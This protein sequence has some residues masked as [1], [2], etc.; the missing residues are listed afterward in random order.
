MT[1]TRRGM[2]IGT[3]GLGMAGLAPG[4]AFAAD[5]S[6]WEGLLA[7]AK[8][9]TVYFHAWGGGEQINAYIG[10]AAGEMQKRHGFEVRHVQ[11]TDTANVVQT[12][13]AEKTAGKTSGGSVDLVWINGENFAAMKRE[14]L[15]QARGWAT[16]LPDYAYVDTKGKPT[17][18]VDFTIPTDGLE[19]PWGMAQLVF[20]YDSAMTAQPPKSASAYLEYA[21]VH[22]GRLA[23][24]QP[25]DFMGSTFLKQILIETIADPALL[26][27][28]LQE[29]DFDTA[30]APLFAYLDELTPN[31]WRSGK[32]YPQNVTALMQ[33]LSDDEIDIAFAFNPS[34]AS[35]DVETGA[36]PDTVRGYVFDGGTIG[37]THFVA[38]PFNASAPAGAMVFA[39]FLMSPEAQARK[40]DA[41]VWGDP[42]VLDVANLPPDQK[43]Y[44]ANVTRGVAT[45]SPEELGRVLPEPHPSWMEA[46]ERAWTARYGAT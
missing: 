11:V 17:T 28:P 26:Q 7:E 22:P 21:Q 38:I 40:A 10:W 46:I 41:A 36:L 4:W 5:P 32:A 1:I 14:G 23:Y 31:L 29:A 20:F 13:L 43:K 2:L 3:A 33:L 34:A 18:T 42:T 45:P 15:L 19:A 8:G 25:P 16:K 24:P 30:T 6:N 9:K 44:F 37:N 12:V 35:N 27:K 39:D